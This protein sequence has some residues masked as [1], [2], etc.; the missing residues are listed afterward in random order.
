MAIQSECLG[1]DSFWIHDHFV[2]QP[3][4]FCKT[5]MLETWTLL[6]ALS[7]ETSKL[8]LGTLVLCNSYRNPALLAKMLATLDVISNGRVDFG[9]GT[10][11]W[12][13]EHLNYGYPFPKGS[14]RRQK[15][16]ES[17][18][19]I[20]KLLTQKITNFEG[21]HFSVK[22]AVCEPKPIQ[23]PHPPIWVGGIGNNLLKLTAKHADGCNF[24]YIT[25]ERFKERLEY[26]KECC[27]QI[28][29]SFDTITKS[30]ETSVVFGN[31]KKE[32]T[33]QLINQLRSP[34]RIKEMVRSP[35]EAKSVLSY[36]YYRPPYILS[37]GPEECAEK[38]HKFVDLGVTY[39]M[40]K[41]P[42]DTNFKNL[43]LFAKKIIPQF[44]NS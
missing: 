35:K 15:L 18:E 23:K 43:E 2:P 24:C 25:F 19:I 7:T 36:R 3:G 37:G 42:F 20:K 26:L 6:S 12:E 44:K 11:G 34:Q 9:I 17:L 28:G 27:N 1:F 32:I 29:R 10:G 40:L 13:F 38:I 8:R 21:T 22:N 33:R 4:Y 41:F 30:F 5:P 16:D 14:V 39:F 31:Y